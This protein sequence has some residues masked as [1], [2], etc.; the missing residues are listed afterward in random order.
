MKKTFQI[1]TRKLWRHQNGLGYWEWNSWQFSA[2]SSWKHLVRNCYKLG[3][4]IKVKLLWVEKTSTLVC[5]RVLQVIRKPKW[6]LLKVLQWV[7]LSFVASLTD[8]SSIFGLA[9]WNEFFSLAF[10]MFVHCLTQTSTICRKWDC[11]CQCS[12]LIMI[13]MLTL[14]W[15]L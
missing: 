4:F 1:G 11:S 12:H 7:T 10:H 15:L 6:D 3:E 8:K 9:I 14:V 5:F 2:L 13:L